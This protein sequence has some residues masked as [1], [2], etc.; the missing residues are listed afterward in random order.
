V[1]YEIAEEIVCPH[2]GQKIVV[3]SVVDVEPPDKDE[4]D[5]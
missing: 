4:P 2:C 3:N 5:L 1:E